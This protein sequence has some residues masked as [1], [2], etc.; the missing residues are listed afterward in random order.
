MYK[1]KKRSFLAFFPSFSRLDKKE[2]I[3][4]KERERGS[5][6]TF[7]LFPN[8]RVA[9][10]IITIIVTIISP[11]SPLSLPSLP[12]PLNL[13]HLFPI[14]SSPPPHHRHDSQ[15]MQFVASWNWKQ[16][17]NQ[18]DKLWNG[19]QRIFVTRGEKL[20]L[21]FLSHS[22]TKKWMER[23]QEKNTDWNYWVTRKKADDI[24]TDVWRISFEREEKE[25]KKGRK[26]KADEHN[27]WNSSSKL[28]K[29]S[30]SQI[31]RSFCVMYVSLSFSL[32]LRVCLP[33]K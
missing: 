16:E 2:R 7:L 27:H 19:N 21:S 26:W 20:P 32:S 33:S 22:L 10:R 25:T 31:L 12:F 14:A 15:S 23:R 28:K 24:F 1:S 13:Q 30:R 3:W 29:K 6:K 8:T 9:V 11:S 5:G 17:R 18:I 4:K